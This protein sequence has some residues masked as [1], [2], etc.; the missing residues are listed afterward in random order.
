VKTRSLLSWLGVFALGFLAGVVFSAWKLDRSSIPVR[1]PLPAANEQH[2]DADTGSRIASLEKMVA[3]NPQNLQAI[4]QLGNEHFDAGN[5]EKAV[6]FYQRA[7]QIEPRNPDV[8]TDMGVSYRKLGKISDAVGAFRKAAEIEPDH[9][10]ALFNLGL[11]LRDDLNDYPEALK[12]W[13]AFLRKSGD[14]PHAVM[15]R[16]WV[17]QLQEKLGS[18]SSSRDKGVGN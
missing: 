2:R 15:V 5:H 12:A 13:E 1:G 9:P 14:S 16:P 3:A 7:L 6:E 17:K 4:T 11:V 18:D 10:I 8:L